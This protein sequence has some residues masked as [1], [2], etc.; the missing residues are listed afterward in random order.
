MTSFTNFSC[1]ILFGAMKRFIMLIILDKYVCN[2]CCTFSIKYLITY[3]ES[4]CA[5]WSIFRLAIT[6]V[7]IL[8]L[9]TET[10]NRKM[11]E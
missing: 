10:Q 6:F 1:Q 3:K 7:T 2:L 8:F 9:D 5:Q 11:N 4:I